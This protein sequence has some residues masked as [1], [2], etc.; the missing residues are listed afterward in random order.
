MHRNVLNGEQHLEACRGGGEMAPSG[1]GD[2]GGDGRIWT[3]GDPSGVDTS[4]RLVG[5]VDLTGCCLAV[6]SVI[7]TSPALGLIMTIGGRLGH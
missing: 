5:V 1:C 7:I 4:L 3:G 6:G 2:D